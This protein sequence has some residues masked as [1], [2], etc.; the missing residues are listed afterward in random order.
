MRRVLGVVALVV[1]IGLTIAIAGC[2]KPAAPPPNAEG[3]PGS[4][5]PSVAPSGEKAETPAPAPAEAKEAEPAAEGETPAE[6]KA[7]EP[8]AKGETPAE[9][10]AKEP[11]EEGATPQPAAKGDE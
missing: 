1:L 10:A 11:A 6:A 7:G 2:P 3:T 9:P 4:N 5:E 8:A